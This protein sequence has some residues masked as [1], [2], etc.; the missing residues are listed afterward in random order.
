MNELTTEVRIELATFAGACRGNLLSNRR[1]KQAMKK[2]KNEV[3]I[4]WKSG[5]INRAI[6][7][8]KVRP[9]ETPSDGASTS[10]FGKL[11]SDVTDEIKCAN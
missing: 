2:V 3:I 10:I 7:F 9:E 11:A 1:E 6:I 4:K 8:F 5:F